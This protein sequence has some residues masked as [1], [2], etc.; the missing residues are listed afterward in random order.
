MAKLYDAGEERRYQIPVS[1]DEPDPILIIHEP[2]HEEFE[3][4]YRQRLLTLGDDSQVLGVDA[5]FIDTLLIDCK[6]IEVRDGNS[7]WISLTNEMQNWKKRIPAPW[8]QAVIADFLFKQAISVE[9]E[10]K[11]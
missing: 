10:T 1:G 5:D 11:K 8:K 3:A 7:G 4:F 9:A 6:E 2:S